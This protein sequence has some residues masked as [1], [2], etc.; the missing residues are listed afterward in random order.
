MNHQFDKYTSLTAKQLAEDD[1]FIRFVCKAESKDIHFWD[2]FLKM[3]PEK[4]QIVR[5]AKLLI[6]ALQPNEDLMTSSEIQDLWTTLSSAHTDT[7]SA[8]KKVII[9]DLQ[10]LKKGALILT[11]ACILILF[12]VVTSY[13]FSKNEVFLY[14]TGYDQIAEVI[15]PDSSKVT[16]NANSSIRVWSSG[17]LK[18]TR[19]V[20]LLGEAHFEVKKQITPF[21]TKKMLVRTNLGLVEV[22][23]TTFNVYARNNKTNVYLK[24]GKV[25]LKDLPDMPE[26]RMHA[27]DYIQYDFKEKTISKKKVDL[28]T[29]DSWMYNKVIFDKTSLVEV[30]VHIKEVH[31]YNFVFRNKLLENK[32]FTGVLPSDDLNILLKALKEAFEI[33]ITQQDNTFF[34]SNK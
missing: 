28:K 8:S 10:K 33:K 18:K 6:Q 31:G 25:L 5:E 24:E 20:A 27:G 29:I 4:S 7:F 26:I 32:S 1:A 21:N 30:F 19:E 14:K 9:F 23:G 22:T 11:A 2:T 17:F 12:G 16:L 13:L 3:Y 15:L 34:I